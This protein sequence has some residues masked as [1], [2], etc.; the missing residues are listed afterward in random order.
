[1][2]GLGYLGLGDIAKAKDCF[3]RVLSNDN[4]HFGAKTH[5][6]LSGS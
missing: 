1:M 2:M 4:M 6:L 5:L 3:E